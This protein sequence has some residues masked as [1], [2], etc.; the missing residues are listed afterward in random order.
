MYCRW[1]SKF[2]SLLPDREHLFINLRLNVARE[3]PA[4]TVTLGRLWHSLDGVAISSIEPRF[5]TCSQNDT[6]KT[7]FGAVPI[8][9][10]G[11]EPPATFAASSS[12]VVDATYEWVYPDEFV[13]IR[14][15]KR[16]EL[17]LVYA[18]E[19][20]PDS[21][22]KL[23]EFAVDGQS[24]VGYDLG[25]DVPPHS[26]SDRR[27]DSRRIAIAVVLFLPIDSS[28]MLQT[29]FHGII[30]LVT[31]YRRDS[32]RL[33]RKLDEMRTECTT[34]GILRIVNSLE[35]EGKISSNIF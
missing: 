16:A 20:T 14:A 12:V 11:A 9:C 32:K 4:Q 33:R 15:R 28:E 24:E 7:G 10:P 25:Y 29:L 23:R 1:L 31:R 35:K 19:G 17:C 2:F 13:V 5:R 6:E 27:L 3:S 22:S 21:I 18:S 26:P 8:L 34:R 30:I